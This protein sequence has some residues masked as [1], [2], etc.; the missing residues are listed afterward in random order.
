MQAMASGEES[1]VNWRIG[2]NFLDK[3]SKVAYQLAS[4]RTYLIV[5]VWGYSKKLS[6]GGEK[7]TPDATLTC[8]SAKSSKSKVNPSEDSSKSNTASISGKTS[9]GNRRLLPLFVAI[10]PSVLSILYNYS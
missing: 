3:G 10:L 8:L 9:S 1:E 5:D 7:R 6:G 2:T 4:N